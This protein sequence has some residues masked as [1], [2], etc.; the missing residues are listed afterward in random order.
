MFLV[1]PSPTDS[2]NTGASLDNPT[3]EI[4]RFVQISA[5]WIP[6]YNEIIA[7]ALFFA[8]VESEAESIGSTRVGK[9][10]AP[11]AWGPVLLISVY[12]GFGEPHLPVR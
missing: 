2:R 1:H 5:A 12:E 10:I 9:E 6:Q 8:V 7:H 11:M 3:D 4:S